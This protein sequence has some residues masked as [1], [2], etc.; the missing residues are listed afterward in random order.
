M[1]AGDSY[2]LGPT[3]EFRAGEWTLLAGIPVEGGR[4]EWLL[5]HVQNGDEVFSHSFVL[6]PHATA[7]DLES[8]LADLPTEVSAALIRGVSEQSD[9]VL[10]SHDGDEAGL[11]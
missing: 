7:E 1:T 2:W 9:P 11:A 10:L 5:R 4:L 6:D 8:A 3:Y